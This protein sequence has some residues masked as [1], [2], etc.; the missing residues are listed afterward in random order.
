MVF[1]HYFTAHGGRKILFNIYDWK[2]YPHRS[3]SI[4]SHPIY[5]AECAKEEDAENLCRI[6]NELVEEDYNNY[7]NDWIFTFDASQNKYVKIKGTYSSARE[8]MFLAFGSNWC[9]QYHDIEAANVADLKCI[10]L[11]ETDTGVYVTRG[12]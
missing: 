11:V 2:D 12:Y 3:E 8:A 5:F 7:K 1:E 9:A 4:D 6:L 10:E